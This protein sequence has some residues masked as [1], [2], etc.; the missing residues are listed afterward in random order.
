[1]QSRLTLAT[2]THGEQPNQGSQRQGGH[3]LTTLRVIAQ[4]SSREL[5]LPESGQSS[6]WLIWSC[7]RRRIA[8]ARATVSS[9]RLAKP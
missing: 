7:R 4:V 6:G 5:L 2:S 8:M 3:Y 1:V 9:T